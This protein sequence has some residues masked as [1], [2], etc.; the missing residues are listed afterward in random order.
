VRASTKRTGAG[1]STGATA[2]S[3]LATRSAWRRER[4]LARWRLSTILAAAVAIAAVGAVLATGLSL[5]GFGIPA[6]S[7]PQLISSGAVPFGL[8]SRTSPPTAPPATARREHTASV[9]LYFVTQNGHLAPV[10]AEIPRPVTIQSELNE[11]FNGPGSA[12]AGSAANLLTGIP[13]GTSVLSVTVANGLAT[14][15]LSPEIENAI[16]EELIQAFA[17]MVYTITWS[18][19]CPQKIDTRPLPPHTTTTAPYGIETPCVDKIIFQVDGVPQEVPIADGA[20][21]DK[22]ITRA[23]YKSLL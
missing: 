21:T 22:P 12:Q 23:D 4:L 1:A 18:T 15:D 6:D 8:L 3:A 2:K 10:Y 9:Y 19:G 20:Q 5:G 17:Q 11:L 14:L 13:A 7:S 16:G